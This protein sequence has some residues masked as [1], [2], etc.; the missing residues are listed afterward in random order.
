MNIETIK[1]MLTYIKQTEGML[2]ILEENKMNPNIT[3][4]Q[5]HNIFQERF[6]VQPNSDDY[7]FCN[8]YCFINNLYTYICLIRTCL[9]KELPVKKI[10]KLEEEWG[11]NELDQDLFLQD[12]IKD[13]RNAIAHGRV[14]ITPELI[15]EFSKDG[16]TVNYRVPAQNIQKFAAKLHEFVVCKPKSP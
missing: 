5:I 6:L 14:H 11:L 16:K 2:K 7:S 9:L 13:I 10:S 8:Q 15:C 12:F 1:Q 3:L 4:G